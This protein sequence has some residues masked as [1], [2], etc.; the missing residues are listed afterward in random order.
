[1]SEQD[2]SMYAIEPPR[3]DPA[4]EHILARLAQVP[5]FAGLSREQLLALAPIVARQRVA[6]NEVVVRQGETGTS[7]FIVDSGEVV[8]IALDAKGERT[9]PR[10][11][12]PGDS[13]GET[14]LLVGEP[15][16]A[17]I[18]VKEAGELLRID[19]DDFYRL[20]ARHRD[21]WESLAVRPDVRIKLSAPRFRW[22]TEGEQVEWFGRKHWIVLLRDVMMPLTLWGA[23]SVLLILLERTLSVR[24][25]EG[26]SL[27]A[28][29]AILPWL[30]WVFIDWRNDYHVVT[31]RRVVHAEVVLLSYQA[32]DEAP[33]DK[34][35]NISTQRG[36][37]G[38]SLGFAHMTITTAAGP[39]G[40]VAFRWVT[41]PELVTQVINEQ[42][43]RFKSRQ[44]LRGREEIEQ[45]LMERLTPGA[46]GAWWEYQAPPKE[47]RPRDVLSLLQRRRGCATALMETALYSFLMR[48][49]LPRL[50]VIEEEGSII[51]RKH[52]V[53]LLRQI[54][55]PAFLLAILC[56]LVAYGLY[57]PYPGLSRLA[58]LV[59]SALI[60]GVLLFWL[61]WGYEDW[62]NDIYALTRTQIIDIER[63]PFLFRETRRQA[64][65]D[66]IQDIRFVIPGFWHNLLNM[67]NV[68]IQTAGQ[69][70]FTFDSVYDPSA[71]QR[72]IFMRIEDFRQQRREEERREREHEIADWFGVYT[73]KQGPP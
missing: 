64:S 1:M 8:S 48:P 54:A 66:N 68:I 45:L 31:N 72:E 7:L 5:L 4:T 18:R 37:L 59:V 6:A 21:I 30:V 12:E 36:A 44:R 63:M 27:I 26:G 58:L 53:I 25:A 41:Q 61:T 49:H 32:R 19:K 42:I 57:R 73:E 15:R 34:I 16:D 47:E 22:L 24:I 65:L 38:N 39:G 60:A 55:A 56:L 50:G 40:R 10:F 9:P 29:L 23:I 69:G 28:L 71:V 13:F 20:I 11:F 70:Q 67:G 35:Q 3:T 52:W 43:R 17:T 14:S 33:L 2:I 51:W 62:R 46:E